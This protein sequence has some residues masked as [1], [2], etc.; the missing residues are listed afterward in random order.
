MAVEVTAN[1]ISRCIGF[2]SLCDFLAGCDCPRG[3]GHRGCSDG[4]IR[5]RRGLVR[6]SRRVPAVAAHRWAGGVLEVAVQLP[7]TLRQAHLRLVARSWSW[8]A[9]QCVAMFRAQMGPS[10]SADCPATGA[11]PVRSQLGN[12]HESLG[13]ASWQGGPGQ[14][15]PAAGTPSSSS[16][17][18]RILSCTW[19]RVNA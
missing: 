17:C 3:Y 10:A 19:R 13:A 4:L 1:L 14:R 15:E 6:S 9:G 11:F 2:H 8:T 12:D 18:S 5:C 7:K 16:I